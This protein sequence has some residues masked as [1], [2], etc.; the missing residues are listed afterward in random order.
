MVVRTRARAILFPIVFYVVL[1][2]ASGY[3]VRGAWNGER[4]LKTKAEDAAEMQGLE[5]E[6]KQLQAERQ[7]WERRVALMRPE[8]VDRDLLDEEARAVLDRVGKNDLLVFTD[9]G[10]GSRE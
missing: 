4:G 8:A 1:G 3:L 9:Q 6:L 2:V 7:S 5:S 10:L